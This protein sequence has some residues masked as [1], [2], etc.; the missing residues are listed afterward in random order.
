VQLELL[1]QA[2]IAQD[3][4]YCPYSRFPVGA[5]LYFSIPGGAG[6]IFSGC[7]IE[8]ASLGLTVCAERNAL[9]AAVL[10]GAEPGSL[11]AI[12]VVGGEEGGS[13][14]TPCG[15][16]RQVLAEFSRPAGEDGGM[17]VICAG[18]WSNFE[19]G[20]ADF[21][22]ERTALRFYRLAELLPEAFGL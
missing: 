15:A 18:Q 19:P 12:A 2:A 11:Q 9:A 6:G 7:N 3:L 5:A 1:R 10:A 14:I 22:A 8:N 21:S 4:A 20:S 16:C 17:E 13:P